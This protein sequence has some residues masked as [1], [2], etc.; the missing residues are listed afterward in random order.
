[1]LITNFVNVPLMYL[2]FINIRMWKQKKL[3]LRVFD[4]SAIICLVPI[5]LK[6]IA[7]SGPEQPYESMTY[8][9]HT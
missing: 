4:R 8:R 1:M 9:R 7:K 2:A 3:C 6:G 5:T